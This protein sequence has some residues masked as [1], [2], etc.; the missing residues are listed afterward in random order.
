MCRM[1]RSFTRTQASEPAEPE[2]PRRGQRRPADAD[3]STEL[4]ARALD[5]GQSDGAG[6]PGLLALQRTAGNR[7]VT[8]SVQRAPAGTKAG[9][10]KSKKE[11]DTPESFA[12]FAMGVQ[13]LLNV[14]E[15]DRIDDIEGVAFLDS[16][17]INASQHA[18]L[19]GLGFGGHL[20]EHH[21]RLLEL[22]RAVFVE[23]RSESAE[24][25]RSAEVLWEAIQS[26]VLGEMG[27]APE[28]VDGDV[29][30]I[31]ARLLGVAQKLVHF[32]AYR[33]AHNEA[34]GGV[35]IADASGPLQE[36]KAKEAAESLKEVMD[37]AQKSLQ[38]TKDDVLASILNSG[39]D[40][41]LHINGITDAT[42]DR[43]YLG[44]GK[45]V[46]EI[47]L[48]PGEVVKL[49][50]EYQEK[51]LLGKSVTVAEMGEKILA[52]RNALYEVSLNT[53]K[54]YSVA[55][56][57]AALE[58]GEEALAENWKKIAEWAEGHLKDLSRVAK[59]ATVITLVVTA[60][61]IVEL[62]IEHKWG[63]AVAEA[64]KAGAGLVAGAAL[65]AGGSM[66]VGSIGIV[67]AAEMEGIHGA[68]AM[69]E[70]SERSN[71][72]EAAWSFVD[73]C[74]QAADLDGKQMIADLQLL[75]S[76]SDPAQKQI[77][78]QKLIG[79]VGY[80]IR[81]I[82]GLA[83]Q[84]S[85]TRAIY[86]GGQPELQEALGEDALRILRSPTSWFGDW[87]V[88]VE[89]IRTIF[90]G[91]WTMAEFV[92]KNHPAVEAAPAKK[93]GEGGE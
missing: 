10:A 72:R 53:V 60:V 62:L 26:D 89:Q 71:I 47:A 48:T 13:A 43:E 54:R 45:A 92:A 85:N 41:H 36:E 49:M 34:L 4:A 93:E 20:T 69:I 31:T 25:T 21:R 30:P 58:A 84:L 15:Q 2:R 86:L 61:K 82:S 57:E 14:V 29:K 65:G 87:H 28:F 66:M 67:V 38:L 52:F 91:A 75:E 16:A 42:G 70:Y 12:D 8:G 59:V 50:H 76:T 6:R 35:D 7:A 44:I 40:T 37:F 9:G 88:M 23:A 77:I 33:T 22:L 55:M 63:E 17:T 3:A 90:A 1:G 11:T 64:A 39:E 80:W 74:T 24:S 5:S 73:A 81:E 51:G 78:E 68:A 83:G 32:G 46:F 18:K 79:H 56:G 19:V 27:R